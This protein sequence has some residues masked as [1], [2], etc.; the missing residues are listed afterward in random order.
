MINI[1]AFSYALK[2][3]WIRRLITDNCKWHDYI[4]KYV[5]LE[6]L[7]AIDTKYE[8]HPK[9][10]DNDPIKQNLFLQDVFH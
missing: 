3:T 10:S 5:N 4:R 8:G 9:C 7:T 2:V 6:K 1:E